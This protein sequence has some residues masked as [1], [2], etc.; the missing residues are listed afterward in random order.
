MKIGR[1]DITATGSVYNLYESLKK[2]KKIKAELAIT[3]NNLNCNQLIRAMASPSD[4]IESEQDTTSTDLSLFVVPENFD[5]ELST[6]LKRV[7]Y[8]KMIF[9]NVSG[10]VDIKN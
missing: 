8:G 3:S 2:N 7:R 6:K 4:S 10:D 1:S 5:F 9:E